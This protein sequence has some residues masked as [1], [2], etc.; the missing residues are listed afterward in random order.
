MVKDFGKTIPVEDRQRIF[1]GSIQ[2]ENGK[3]RGRGLGLAIVK[4]IAEAHGGKVWVSAGSRGK[5]N[6]PKGNV[7]CLR[8]LK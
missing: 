1:N 2:L 4:R 6:Q 8:L 3:N 7:F 5:A